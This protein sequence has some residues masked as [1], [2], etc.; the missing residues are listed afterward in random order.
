VSSNGE[1]PSTGRRG[2]AG[3]PEGFFFGVAT[4]GFQV[5]GGYNGPGQPANNWEAWEQA[6]RVEPSGNAVGFWDRPDEALDRAAALGCNSFR[7]GVE[8]ARVFPDQRGADRAALAH[9]A[10]IVER[11]IER[12]L[13]PLV[14]L[15]HF[16]H[17]AWSGE[18]FWLR[19]D[20]PRRYRA[21]A[22]VVVDALAPSV[23]HWVTINELNVLAIGSW[24][25]GMFP[26]GRS[27]AFDDAAI[28][29]DNLLAAHV[30]GYEVVHR[31]RADAVV[32]TNNTCL[33]VYEFDRM[34]TDLLLARS[35]GV[36]RGDVDAWIEERRRQHDSLLPATGLTEHLLRRLSAAK[37]PY[38]RGG[39]V[40]GTSGDPQSHRLPRR[41]LD[42]IYDSPHERTLDVLGLDYYDPIVARHFR[43]PGHR[44][45]GGR[46]RLPTRELWDDVV[47]PGGLTRWLGI[48]QNLA[49][50][51]PLWV[52]ENG[53]C[54]RVRNGRS[55]IREDGWDRPR[56]LR[57]NI[58]AV[59]DAIDAGV[60]IAGYWHWSLVDNYEWGSY[61]PRFGLYGVDRHRGEHGMRWLDAD[62]MGDDSAAAYRQII[63]GLRAGDRSV[64]GAS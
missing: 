11:C 45:A 50:G 39:A 26:P 47:D 49:P 8:W 32:T 38:R 7:L 21:W 53:L 15:H 31:A 16:T 46:N 27:L 42:A 41:A 10:D 55:Y 19:P 54:N 29:T 18:D 20:A 6:G 60:P 25:L 13:E 62:S 56:Y 23:R 14:T 24:L 51:L 1:P 48:Q 40:D 33:S 36:V 64:L 3:L 59:V 58:A 4:A 2:G 12:G 28:A 37:S 5:E 30:A 34:L 9:Y 22:E 35:A 52:V 61:E 57:E 17:P 44:T 43:V 63:A